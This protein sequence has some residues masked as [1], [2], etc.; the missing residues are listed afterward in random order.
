MSSLRLYALPLI[1][2]LTLGTATTVQAEEKIV[3][4]HILNEATAHHRHLVQAAEEIARQ[5]KGRYRLE[6]FPRGQIG[7]TD[8]QII[9]GFSTGTADM[10]YLSFGHLAKAYPRLAIGAGPFVF[11]DYAHWQRFAASPLYQELVKGMETQL[12]LQSFGLAYY[13]ERHVSSRKPI[14]GLADLQGLVIRVPNIPTMTLGFRALGA[15][16]VPIAFKETYQALKDGVVD[17]Q[18]NPL[19]TIK[20]MKFHEVTPVINL[21]AHILDAQIVVMNA[22][23]WKRIPEA[24]QA[25]LRRIFGEVARRVTDDV[26]R[27]ELALMQSLVKE[28]ATLHTLDRAPL[29][30]AVKPFHHS[31]QFP[32]GGELYDRIQALN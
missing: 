10:A 16:P 22:A 11:R 14:Q 30:N 8:A 32:W 28:G 4:G 1:A 25:I 29:I 5:T 18:E 23:R 21:T 3:F 17:A 6:I 20:V 26:R 24:D 9:E 12:G 7:T 2:C 15:K 31:D 13:G 19:P 27:E